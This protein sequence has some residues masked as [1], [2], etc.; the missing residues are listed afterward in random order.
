M[1]DLALDLKKILLG[2]KSG[3]GVV[4][5]DSARKLY[6]RVLENS[7]RPLDEISDILQFSMINLASAVTGELP[8]VP[9]VLSS[10]S[11]SLSFS[12]TP[13][14]LFQA[15]AKSIDFFLRP[16]NSNAL[17]DLHNQTAVD[18]GLANDSTIQVS[19]RL[20]HCSRHSCGS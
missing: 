17:R 3:Q 1:H 2:E 20:S 15:C 19:R 7:S 13:V 18:V 8:N 14:S 4:M 6:D 16:E 9:F 12:L 11:L 10:W 5:S